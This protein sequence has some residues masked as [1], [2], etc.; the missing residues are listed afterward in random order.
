MNGIGHWI[1]SNGIAALSCVVFCILSSLS[2]AQE[3]S[4]KAS[5]DLAT[6]VLDD[7]ILAA[8]VTF[9]NEK[10]FLVRGTS[11]LPATER[12]NRIE[13]RIRLAARSVSKE[14]IQPSIEDVQFGRQISI[15]GN[16]ITITTLAD[17]KLEQIDIDVLAGL[18]AEA[19]VDAILAYRSE[20]STDARVESAV[21]ALGWSIGFVILSVLFFRSKDKAGE[22]VAKLVRRRFQGLEQATG[23]VVRGKALAN[24]AKFG[25]KVLLWVFYLVVLYYYLTFVLLAFAET[26][27]FA[28]ALLTYVSAPLLGIFQGFVDQLPNLITLTIIAIVTRYALNALKLF[29]D[30]LEAGTFTLKDFEPHWIGPTFYL[31]R[32]MVILIALVFSYPFIPGSDSVVFQ[33]LTILAGIMVSLGSN[34]VVSN[35]MA[36]LFVIYRRSTNVG[37][38]IEVGDR[39]GD[40]VDIKLMETLIKSTKNEMISIPNSQLLNS[41]VV[42]FTR[43]IDGSGLLLY[44]TVGIG[45]EEP[46]E[47]VKAMLIEA[48]RRTEGL[49]KN[50]HP[51]VLCTGLADYAVNY[52][53][54]AYSS[55]GAS[56][57]KILSDL[58]ENILDVFN[59]NGVQIM[60]P[61]YEADPTEPKI[62]TEDWTGELH[63]VRS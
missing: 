11:V 8:P 17:A 56:R 37:D 40:V 42:N 59:E 25:V 4:D 18:Q 12:A 41:E 28:E 55:R 57:P 19:I 54:N 21:S 2:S 6:S 35:M 60:T 47:K 43:K 50:P 36:G 16:M 62:P 63:S 52:Q 1:R 24:L 33:G 46:K 49:K 32:V 53:I 22:M 14:K 29:F 15:G 26:R 34:T 44:T 38:R 7:G 13:E 31:A 58:H 9:E 23:A 20:R 39:V 27:P 61:S 45:Y 3:A 10:L 30:N 5:M 51:F 48:S